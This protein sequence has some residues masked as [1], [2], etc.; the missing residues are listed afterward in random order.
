MRPVSVLVETSVVAVVAVVADTSEARGIP[1][2][3]SCP[4][5]QRR[6]RNSEHANMN[7]ATPQHRPQHRTEPNDPEA[8]PC[9]PQAA[10]GAPARACGG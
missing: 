2:V 8:D 9:H 6:R 5:A 3:S 4:R 10:G 1:Y 7:T